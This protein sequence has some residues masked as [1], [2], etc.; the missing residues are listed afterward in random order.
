TMVRLYDLGLLFLLLFSLLLG[1]FGFGTLFA[2]LRFLLAL[3][4]NFGLGRNCLGGRH[5]FGWRHFFFLLQNN[6]VR[7][8]TLRVS[9]QFHFLR[10]KRQIGRAELLTDGQAADIDFEFLRNIGG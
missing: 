4:D 8:N 9:H 6:D 7:Q 10:I 5:G 3:L 2:F 1:L